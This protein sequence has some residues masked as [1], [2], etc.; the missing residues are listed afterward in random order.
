MYLVRLR[1]A[2]DGPRVIRGTLLQL[3]NRATLDR[4]GSRRW[5]AAVRWHDGDELS[6]RN[7][8]LDVDPRVDGRHVATGRVWLETVLEDNRRFV[9]RRNGASRS[10]SRAPLAG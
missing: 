1:R 10:Q 6:G 8:A 7:R 5:S 4:V 3:W 2:G 9:P